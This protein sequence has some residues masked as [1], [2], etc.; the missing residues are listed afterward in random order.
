MGSESVRLAARILADIRQGESTTPAMRA[1]RRRASKQIADLDRDTVLELAHELIRRAS[2]ARFV[3]YELV[4]HHAAAMQSI[5]VAEVEALGSG[6][7]S[8]SDVDTFAPS[9]AGPA[10]RSGRIPDAAIRRWAK[11]EDRWWR[12]AALVSTVPLNAA[13]GGDPRRTFAICNILL[14]DRD[15]M[16]VKAMSWALRALAKRA[17]EEVTQYLAA[18][19]EHLAPRVI[20][21]V[22]NK[23]TT[24][25]KNPRKQVTTPVART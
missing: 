7:Q 12:R 11:S 4:Q 25:L 13:A 9:I 15:D 18:N 19:R 14:S 3:A 5:T 10:W 1:I 16:V 6:I 20:R 2:F 8:W 23:L 21:E 24:G 22:S 17:P